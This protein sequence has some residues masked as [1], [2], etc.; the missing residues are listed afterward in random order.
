MNA[1][2]DRAGLNVRPGEFIVLTGLLYVLSWVGIALWSYRVDVQRSRQ[3][4]S[5]KGDAMG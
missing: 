4:G 2:L 3:R 5:D 1:A